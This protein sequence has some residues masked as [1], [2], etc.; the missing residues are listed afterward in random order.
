SCLTSQVEE[1]AAHRNGGVFF[2][3][4][5]G[6]VLGL[7]DDLLQGFD[8]A[9]QDDQMSFEARYA[10]GQ[11]LRPRRGGY[12]QGCH[13][14]HKSSHDQQDRQE[15]SDPGYTDTLKQTHGGLQNELQYESEH[16]VEYDRTCHVNGRQDGQSQQTTEKERLRIGRQRH[17]DI[18]GG[19]RWQG[20]RFRRPSV[21]L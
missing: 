6:D 10:L 19:L 20:I 11:F 17:L 5:V 15:C 9:L 2:S 1:F 12:G 18:V 21:L 3:G 4:S 14:A 16:D 7:L 8:G 13:K